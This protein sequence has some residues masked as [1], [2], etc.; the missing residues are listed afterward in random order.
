MTKNLNVIYGTETSQGSAI[1]RPNGQVPPVKFS[2]LTPT[3]P[4]GSTLPKD[5]KMQFS[6]PKLL[7]IPETH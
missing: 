1:F 2:P 6:W 7:I 3:G 4:F 5:R